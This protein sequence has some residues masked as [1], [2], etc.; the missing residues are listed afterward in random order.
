M[1]GS[2]QNKPFT[3]LCGAMHT[4]LSDV[5]TQ[6]FKLL[7]ERN[8]GAVA[9]ADIELVMKLGT[10]PE[11]HD[12]HALE[13]KYPELSP[14]IQK[15]IHLT[16]VFIE[17]GAA[18]CHESFL[19]AV[20]EKMAGLDTEEESWIRSERAF[21]ELIIYKLLYGRDGQK[22]NR[23]SGAHI[24]K[25]Y[26]G[27][28]SV[29]HYARE[30]QDPGMGFLVHIDTCRTVMTAL[31]RQYGDAFCKLD[32][33]EDERTRQT[34]DMIRIDLA[35]LFLDVHKRMDI[36]K[37]SDGRTYSVPDAD[38]LST[39]Y[40]QQKNWFMSMLNGAPSDD[41]CKWT[42]CADRD[43][44]WFMGREYYQ[45]IDLLFGSWF[46]ALQSKDQ[47][48]RS[49]FLAQMQKSFGKRSVK[50]LEVFMGAYQE[51]VMQQRLAA[52]LWA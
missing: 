30:K 34:F 13:M 22:K 28:V 7:A 23:L 33:Y 9:F 5:R 42:P 3:A 51:D 12:L 48:Q 26:P 25:L 18:A 41:A 14:R 44:W 16:G 15:A 8:D 21:K 17:C 2:A 50:A 29:M 19:K 39:P 45:L 1:V 52:P 47:R 4:H 36:K 37:R 10:S 49:M 40:G 11:P 46:R 31:E 38:Y 32:F 24:R 35:M 27:L 6:I 20:P 43:Q